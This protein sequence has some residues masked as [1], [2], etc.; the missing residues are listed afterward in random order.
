M[1]H[2]PKKPHGQFRLSQLVTTYGPGA[3]ADLPKHSVLVGGLEQWTEGPL[4][5]EP[6]LVDK[7]K[8]LFPEQQ[9]VRLYAP[10]PANEDDEEQL[11]GVG[12]W[13]FPEWFLTVT[14]L[15]RA[16]PRLR[17][18]RLVHRKSLI[19]GRFQDEDRRKHDVVPVRFV[20]ACVHG[21]IDDINWHHFVHSGEDPCRLRPLWFDERGT[22]GDVG[23]IVVRCEC[24][25]QRQIS[26]ATL[27]GAEAPIRY[28]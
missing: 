16:E 23:D 6:R 17:S 27:P 11:T 28:W 21:H 10:P 14:N 8:L 25:K 3:S 4:I 19:Q 18:R 15:A 9:S 7:I 20:R 1:R 5:S 26:V 12:V 13:L 22:S 24:G 2:R